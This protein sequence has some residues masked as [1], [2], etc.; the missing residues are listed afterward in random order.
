[1]R[2]LASVSEHLWRHYNSAERPAA[3]LATLWDRSLTHEDR[4]RLIIE[5]W[6]TFDAIPHMAFEKWFAQERAYLRDCP[7]GL[8]RLMS[9]GDRAS[10]LSIDAGRRATVIYRGQPEPTPEGGRL[11]LSWTTDPEVA[12]Q[13]A[14]GHRGQVA[15]NP[16]IYSIKVARND[17]AFCNNDRGESEVVLW[18]RI[19]VS[20]TTVVV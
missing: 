12:R 17:V 16:T 6:P 18:K 20:K 7:D 2:D 1:M 4:W 8:A 13:F 11:G 5:H 9:D 19:S 3:V 15:T 14:H 10:F